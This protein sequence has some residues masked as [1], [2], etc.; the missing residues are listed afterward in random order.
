MN[1]T[2]VAKVLVMEWW[3]ASVV[4]W[5]PMNHAFSSS[6]AVAGSGTADTRLWK[7]R[8]EVDRRVVAQTGP[9][10]TY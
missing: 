9:I 2:S 6:H 10:T 3:S 4:F 1:V 7:R 5:I 8:S